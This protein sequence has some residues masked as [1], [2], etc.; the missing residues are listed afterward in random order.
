MKE[1]IQVELPRPR[2]EDDAA[3]LK[4]KRKLRDLIHDEME[5]Q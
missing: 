4:L 1:F 2:D 3:Y 5:E